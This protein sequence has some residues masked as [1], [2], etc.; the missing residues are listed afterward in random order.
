MGA[1]DKYSIGGTEQ[2]PAPETGGAAAGEASPAVP[3]PKGGGRV[4]RGKAGRR[5]KAAGQPD[6]EATKRRLAV[7][8]GVATAIAVAAVG[9]G[10]TQLAAAMQ[11][12]QE[13][14]G[15]TEHVA[16]LTRSVR[17][18][19]TISEADLELADVPSASAPSDATD[20]LS[21]IAGKVAIVDMTE[22]NAVSQNSLMG[23]EA[24][25]SLPTAVSEGNVGYMMSLPSTDAAASPMLKPGDRVDVLA[26]SDGAEPSV[27]VSDV[28]VIALDGRMG[29]EGDQADY[30]TV[31]LDVTPEQASQLYQAADSAH[32]LVLPREA[33]KGGED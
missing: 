5:E 30:S 32:L 8:C 15:S 17:A 1:F 22:G 18:G 11:L 14:L 10:G 16:T 3:A 7:A 27:I 2:P 26:G 29:R 21:A 20:D 28:R 9:V 33:A 31:T 4:R 24:A 13:V 25:T 6:G 12:R 23:S 19:E